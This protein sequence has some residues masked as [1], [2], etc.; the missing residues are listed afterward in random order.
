MEPNTAS[1]KLARRIGMKETQT[2][3]RYPV[4]RGR[5]EAVQVFQM[6][7]DGYYDLPY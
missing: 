5:T 4:E 3:L 6:Q 1:M 7:Q 2:Q